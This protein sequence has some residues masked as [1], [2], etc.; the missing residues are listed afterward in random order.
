ML[1]NSKISNLFAKV[2]MQAFKL[3]YRLQLALTG[4]NGKQVSK[5]QFN[6]LLA[7]LCNKN[8]HFRTMVGQT[9]ALETTLRN[10]LWKL[11]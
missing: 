1:P 7:N 10:Y 6:W 11:H 4:L 9:S 2:A 5:S 8:K 3:L